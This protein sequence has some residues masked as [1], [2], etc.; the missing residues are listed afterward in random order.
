V[1]TERAPFAW[2]PVTAVAAGVTV[3]LLVTAGGY[4]YHRD[5]LY[6]R[7]LGAHPAWGYV[8]EPPLTPLLVRASTALFGDS[9]LGLRIPAIACAAATVLIV[10]LICHELGGGR[11]AQVTTAIGVCCTFLLVAG[12]VFLTASPDMVFWTLTVLFVVRALLRSE[13]RWWLAAG[14]TVGVGLYNKQL[15]V[16]LLIGHAV[17]L[18]LAGPRNVFRDRRLWLG[19]AL[20]AVIGLPTVLYQIANGWPELHMAHAIAVN[21]GPDDRVNFVPFQ[22]LLLG[23]GLVPVWV[24]GLLGLLR[25][26]AWRPVRALGWAY[27]VVSIIVL[28]T[29]GQ[30]YYTFGL[31]ALYLAAGCVRAERWVAAG[32]RTGWI[33][34]AL[35]TSVPFGLVIALPLVPVAH[36]GVIGTINQAARDQVGWPAYVRQVAAAYAAL[37]AADRART[38]VLA[39]NYGEA[40][41]IARFGPADGLPTAVYSGQN[42]LY[43]YGPPPESDTAAVAVG[44]DPDGL[45]GAFATCE[46]VGTLDNGVGVDNEEQGRPILVCRGRTAPWAALWPGF[47]HYD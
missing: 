31:L 2:R 10:A 19:A 14:V 27:P 39:Q 1:I 9:L 20:A 38:A 7:M 12:H 45:A 44:F 34:A 8:D 29:G 42:Q 25:D 26:P 32:R 21:K 22:L 41:A 4:G 28:V 23:L 17:G 40:G 11:F 30:V 37:P 13:P 46:R 36:L 47:Q 3:L 24:A 6:F 35:A 33:V 18:L 5:E 15:I 16:L 43:H